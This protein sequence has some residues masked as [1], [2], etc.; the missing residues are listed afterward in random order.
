MGMFATANLY[1]GWAICAASNPMSY[2]WMKNIFMFD[3]GMATIATLSQTALLV[4][5]AEMGMNN[6]RDENDSEKPNPL[7]EQQQRSLK[8]FVVL[9]FIALPMQ[10]YYNLPAFISAC[11]MGN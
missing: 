7:I 1:A 10:Y 6:M 9:S 8:V 4:T 11:W 5:G 2:L 3:P